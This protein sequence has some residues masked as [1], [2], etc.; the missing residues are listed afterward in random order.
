VDDGRIPEISFV[1]PQMKKIKNN[2]AEP[3]RSGLEQYA[4]EMLRLPLAVRYA[5]RQRWRAENELPEN[6]I[7]THRLIHLTAG[8][9]NYRVEGVTRKLAAPGILYV[10]GWVRRSW[11]SAGTV[12]TRMSW[13]EF[14]SDVG[15]PGCEAVLYL[16]GEISRFE[17]GGMNE[18]YRRWQKKWGGAEDV[19][20]RVLLEHL[21]KVLLAGFFA[22]CRE[23]GL[24]DG[25]EREPVDREILKLEDYLKSHFSDPGVLQAAVSGSR[26]TPDYLRKLFHR[27]RGQSMQAYVTSLRMRKARY[28]LSETTEQV[29]EV[30]ERCGFRDPLGFSKQYRSFWGHPPSADRDR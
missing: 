16:K 9:L 3:G 25:R 27:H 14:H 8:V 4:A 15:D 24:L 10:P 30:A 6:I 12:E 1:F 7:D 21:A 2:G 18:L 22:D 11:R 29:K 23:R 26:L 19:F 17:S 20:E 13:F 5:R 28:L